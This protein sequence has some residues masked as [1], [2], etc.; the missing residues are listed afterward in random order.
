MDLTGEA[1]VPP[2]LR[3]LAEKRELWKA[4]NK[5][6]DWKREEEKKEEYKE[7]KKKKYKGRRDDTKKWR[8]MF[9]GGGAV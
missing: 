2:G 7:I 6:E 1:K 4:I 9:W 5:K 8:I 3:H